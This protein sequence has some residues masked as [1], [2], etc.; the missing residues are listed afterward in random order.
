LPAQA[1]S[2]ATISRP[3]SRSVLPTDA[4]EPAAVLMIAD[5]QVD[6]GRRVRER[7]IAE[8]P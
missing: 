2:A 5:Q 4:D 6:F 1:G 3:K 8:R 7:R